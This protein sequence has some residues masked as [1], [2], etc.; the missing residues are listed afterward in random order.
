M[1]IAKKSADLKLRSIDEKISLE[2]KNLQSQISAQVT[3]SQVEQSKKLSEMNQLID[4]AIERLSSLSYSADPL[5]SNNQSNEDSSS[6]NRGLNLI[7]VV[8][9]VEEEFNR[10][11]KTQ[12]LYV[13]L[14]E[15]VKEVEKLLNIQS[16]DRLVSEIQSLLSEQSKNYNVLSEN[17]KKVKSDRLELERLKRESKKCEFQIIQLKQWENWARRIHRIIHEAEY[18]HLDSDQLRQALEEALLASVS[19]RSISLR[20]DSLRIQ[21]N[22][23]QRFDKRFL[24]G[25]HNIR[26]SICPIIAI[27]LCI[28]R[29]QK[30]AGCLPLSITNTDTKINIS[31]KRKFVNDRNIDLNLDD[32]IDID[33]DHRPTISLK[34]SLN[35]RKDRETPRKKR[36]SSRHNQSEKSSC[37]SPLKPLIPMFV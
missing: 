33:S 13:D 23:L 12:S 2:K 35:T 18:A 3:A 5:T 19:S 32:D 15:N 6:T 36:S 24:N 17:E 26:P 31:L 29:M 30:H 28:R 14:L 34:K 21:K 9:T 37:K 8:S 7:H 27:C 20:L 11:R 25:H 1:S 10:A 22:I 16:P 4:N